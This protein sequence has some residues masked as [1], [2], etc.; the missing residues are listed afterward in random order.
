M[1]FTDCWSID[2]SLRLP[3]YHLQIGKYIDRKN[4]SLRY[5]LK[6]TKTGEVYFIVLFILEL[7]VQGEEEQED[8]ES[9][10]ESGPPGESEVD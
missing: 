8:E 5:V 7:D 2:F 4:H 10:E 9:E 6:N 1:A 3:G